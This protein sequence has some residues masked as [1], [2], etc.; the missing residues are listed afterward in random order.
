MKRSP[1]LCAGHDSTSAAPHL[2]LR[3]PT[4]LIA[5]GDAVTCVRVSI[6]ST[7]CSCLSV[8]VT[9]KWKSS[10]KR[11]KNPLRCNLDDYICRLQQRN[12]PIPRRPCCQ[13]PVATSLHQRAS[14]TDASLESQQKYYA[15][16][17]SFLDPS[18]F[19]LT[20]TPNEASTY[21][22]RRSPSLMYASC[23][24]QSRWAFRN[25][26]PAF[27]IHPQDRD[28]PGYASVSTPIWSDLVPIHSTYG[29]TFETTAETG[30]TT[31]ACSS[32]PS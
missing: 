14:R 17:S 9:G 24:A 22:A 32:T 11:I 31:S 30:L 12:Q 20:R 25:S 7:D 26:G 6:F 3:G 27:D 2:E 1:R 18:H 5:R 28:M 13:F 21:Q 15:P 10:I 29:W 23:G 4:R 16:F 19:S 8:P